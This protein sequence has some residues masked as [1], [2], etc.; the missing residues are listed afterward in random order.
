MKEKSQYKKLKQLNYY[1]R[2]IRIES[3]TEVGIPDIYYFSKR[4]QNI[5][6]WI[7]NKQGKNKFIGIK[8]R[9][10]P[11]QIKTLNEL[12]QNSTRVFVLI[13][14]KDYLYLT[15]T[16]IPFYSS[17]EVLEKHS[18]WIGKNSVL[19]YDLINILERGV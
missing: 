16:F 11:G 2:F 15:T 12:R 7:E 5:S 17:I 18:I 9:Y 14:Y 8:V 4:K 19:S 13:S 3:S 6:G 1:F 10:E